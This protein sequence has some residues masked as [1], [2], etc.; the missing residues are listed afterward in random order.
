MD[1][2]RS[3]CLNASQLCTAQLT[4][5]YRYSIWVADTWLHVTTTTVLIAKITPIN[6]PTEN[7]DGFG[8]PEPCRGI[9]NNWLDPNATVLP[10]CDSDSQSAGTPGG[11]S[12][13]GFQ[14]MNNLSSSHQVLTSSLNGV[15]FSFLAPQN[16]GPLIDYT[17]TTIA[18][19][20]SCAPTS[21][22][23]QLQTQVNQTNDM[24]QFNCSETFHGVFGEQLY[25]AEF[26]PFCLD[27]SAG[28][29]A[30]FYDE[31]LNNTLS[32]ARPS[33]N[34]YGQYTNPWYVG[35]AAMTSS[36]SGSTT[37]L[38]TSPEILEIN[39]GLDY[40]MLSC[41]INTSILTYS[42]VN[43][44]IIPHDLELAD[45][46][47]GWVSQLPWMGT[48]TVL[49]Q[50]AYSVQVAYVL[51]NTSQQLADNYGRIF[52]QI[53]LAYTA[54]G[55]AEKPNTQMQLRET[56]LV[57][58]IP[59]APLFLLITLCLLYVAL[60]VVLGTV[61]GFSDP[62]ASRDVQARLSVFGLM[63]SRFET[64]EN[65]SAPG[66]TVEDMFEERKGELLSPRVAMVRSED[67]GWVYRS[68]GQEDG[69]D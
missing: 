3:F 66:T 23:C 45:D 69:I 56:M 6:T 52:E 16:L 13:D 5:R 31:G 48:G 21:Q 49:P 38:A 24:P 41:Q 64:G 27:N 28:C 15:S 51:S 30:G 44:T 43:G 14:I 59:K 63:A 18:I 8:L 7:Y 35:V 65:A 26:P 50:M 53:V 17:T 25:S 29:V 22:K 55:W 39:Q 19:S 60:G 67:G 4:Q 68:V 33:K 34:A 42:H 62:A 54:T 10:G 58:R 47:V 36:G 9:Y 40:F 1:L 2:H 20:S 12:A 46:D 11:Q 57:A 61:V 37:S 32:R